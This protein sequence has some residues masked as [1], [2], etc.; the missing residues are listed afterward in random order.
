M[1]KD[2]VTKIER[3]VKGFAGIVPA[4]D[5]QSVLVEL[6]VIRGYFERADQKPKRIHFPKKFTIEHD[7]DYIKLQEVTP[8]ETIYCSD[9]QYDTIV[10]AAVRMQHRNEDFDRWTLQE[11]ARRT[12]P[13]ITVPAIITC[14][15]YWASV[16]SPLI[17][18][19]GVTFGFNCTV[20]EFK[21]EAGVAWNDLL[22]TPLRI[23]EPSRR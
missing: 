11:E 3:I 14:L 22:E 12:D 4:E 16:P 18:K 7:R 1:V 15:H 17:I 8:S 13:R 21:N 6:G 19:N 2:S 10:S 9:S 5:V 23:N 20:D